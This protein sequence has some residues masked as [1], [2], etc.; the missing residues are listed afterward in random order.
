MNKRQF[1]SRNILNPDLAEPSQ[2][3]DFGDKKSSC[4]CILFIDQQLYEA[5]R[6]HS[7]IQTLAINHLHRFSR[8]IKSPFL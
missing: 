4:M 7:Q 6:A 3:K 1:N 5:I 2:I 8:T